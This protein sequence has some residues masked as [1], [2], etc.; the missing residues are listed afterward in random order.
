[1]TYLNTILNNIIEMDKK[2]RAVIREAENYR[3][4]LLIEMDSI[5]EKLIKAETEKTLKKIEQIKIELNNEAEVQSKEIIKSY[6][7][8]LKEI[9]AKLSEMREKWADEI[10]ERVLK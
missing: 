5:K 2:A 10:F 7:E 1:M 4:E 8:S 6:S 9:D 3:D